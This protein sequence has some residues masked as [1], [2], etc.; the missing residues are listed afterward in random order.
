V[1][2]AEYNIQQ[3]K[4]FWYA[5]CSINQDRLRHTTKEHDAISALEIVNDALRGL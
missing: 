2:E 5:A 4:K 1:R 3:A